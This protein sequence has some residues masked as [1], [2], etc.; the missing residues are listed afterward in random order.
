MSPTEK[1]FVTA[2]QQKGC[3]SSPLPGPKLPT[4]LQA[5]SQTS[6]LPEWARGWTAGRPG[7]NVANTSSY[8]VSAR[9]HCAGFHELILIFWNPFMGLFLLLI[10]KSVLSEL[11]W[12][13]QDHIASE[14]AG[15][16]PEAMTV[17]SPAWAMHSH[18]C[19]VAQSCLTLCDPMDCS[20]PGFLVLHYLPEF[21]QT[22]VHWVDDAIQL[23]GYLITDLEVVVRGLSYFK[24]L[25]QPHHDL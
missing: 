15:P 1:Y 3:A 2:Y 4:F 24:T 13:S 7:Q 8:R 21:A 9:S 14:E 25:K 17:V 10:R 6:K 19:S 12:L 5:P 20:P 23:G 16:G 11:T 18:Y 22:R